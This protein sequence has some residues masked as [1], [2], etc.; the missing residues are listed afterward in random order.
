MLF[1]HERPTAWE[2]VSAWIDQHGSV[3]NTDVVRIGK[4]ETLKASKLLRAWVDQ[5]VLMPLPG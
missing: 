4:V 5:G 3:A 2:E 1:N